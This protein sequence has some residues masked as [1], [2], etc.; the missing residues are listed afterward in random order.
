MAGLIFLDIC[1]VLGFLL[2]CIY[3]HNQPSIFIP[4]LSK[5]WKEELP[6]LT[7]LL[8]P[9]VKRISVT[10]SVQVYWLVLMPPVRD[11]RMG[12]KEMTWAAE[13]LTSDSSSFTLCSWI[14]HLKSCQ[15]ECF[16]P[17]P[18]LRGGRR[19]WQ[20]MKNCG[21]SL[22]LVPRISAL[23]YT[24]RLCDA[25]LSRRMLPYTTTCGLPLFY[26]FLSFILRK[27]RG[28][29]VGHPSL[30]QIIE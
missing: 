21:C 25:S 2:P 30:N 22:C 14:I 23:W 19:T 27:N 1:L 16:F 28:I 11:E 24:F 4:I 9:S 6:F 12:S 5:N 29:T 3:H 8:S 18:I 26:T 20:S 17:W 7:D 15:V 13:K 10:E